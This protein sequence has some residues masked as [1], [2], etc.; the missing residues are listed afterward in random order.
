MNKPVILLSVLLCASIAVA[1]WEPDYRITDNDSASEVPA[2]VDRCLAADGECVHVVWLDDESAGYNPQVWHTRSTDRGESWGQPAPIC[3]DT[4]GNYSAS[5]AALDGYV[6]V[7]WSDTRDG[8]GSEVY[9]SRSTDNGETW[10]AN[11]RMTTATGAAN[12]PNAALEGDCVH[13]VWTDR[14]GPQ[15]QVYYKHSPDRGFSWTQD[16]A[17]SALDSGTNHATV[18]VTDS[19]VQ[20]VYAAVHGDGPEVHYVRSLDNGQ[21][22]EP[23][24]VLTSSTA[25]N[26]HMNPHIATA[27]PVVHI[28]YQDRRSGNDEA[29]YIRSPD[30]GL[31][32][33]PEV[34]MFST[35]G[36]DVGRT[37]VAGSGLNAH[38]AAHLRINSRNWIHYRH[39]TDGG[40]TW[41]P[42]ELLSD[43]G[44]AYHTCIAIGGTA[45]HLAWQDGRDA[46]KEVY[47]KRNPTANSG[48]TEEDE[49]GG[50]KVERRMTSVARGVLYVQPKNYGLHMT[51]C[52]LDVSGRKV[53][54]LRPGENDVRALSPGV[55]FLREVDAQAQA[56][57]QAFQKVVVA[58]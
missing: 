30:Y 31:S 36:D 3:T 9:Y 15:N 41:V 24:I 1:Q 22:W 52:L 4:F 11:R 21:S 10:S 29:F 28:V 46:N 44:W 25:P 56:Q 27:G 39:S 45:V 2:Y 35:P 7:F 34:S 8:D 19:V 57:A 38:A 37:V 13:L 55:Y 53:M 47:Y 51:A 5:V 26:G 23:D 14:R 6:H 49:G 33:G 18:A 50:L 54:E 17:I 43:S 40:L 42:M 58:R 48:V 12:E 20:V 32:W 16:L